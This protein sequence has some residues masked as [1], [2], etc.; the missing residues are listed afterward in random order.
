M[1]GFPPRERTNLCRASAP[2]AYPSRPPGL[3]L[4]RLPV[5][6]SCARVGGSERIRTS[7]SYLPPPH[8]GGKQRSKAGDTPPPVC[9]GL[10]SSPPAHLAWSLARGS[11]RCPSHLQCEVNRWSEARSLLAHFHPKWSYEASCI[12]TPRFPGVG[13]LG[14]RPLNREGRLIY[15]VQP[16]I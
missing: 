11:A 5:P 3:P 2:P 8:P 4:P 7:G 10:E 1:L 12:P 13:Y 6:S 14:T 15:C 16:V 9:V